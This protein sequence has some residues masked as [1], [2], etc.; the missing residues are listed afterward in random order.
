M[1]SFEPEAL[2]HYLTQEHIVVSLR[3]TMIRLSPHF[4]SIRDDMDR[5]FQIFDRFAEGN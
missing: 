4:Y 2:Y 3:N 5:F 1:P